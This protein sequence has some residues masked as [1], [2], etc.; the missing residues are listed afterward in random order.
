MNWTQEENKIIRKFYPICYKCKMKKLLPK[1]SFDNIKK[2]ALLLSVFRITKWKV[3]ELI[4][5]NKHKDKTKKELKA[6]FPDRSWLFIK[7]KINIIKQTIIKKEEEILKKNYLK[8]NNRIRLKNPK[9]KKVKKILLHGKK[10]SKKEEEMLK[11]NYLKSNNR[12]K[13]LLRNNRTESAIINKKYQMKLRRPK[14]KIKTTN[15]NQRTNWTDKEKEILKNNY[16]QLGLKVQ[17]LM[18]NR[19]RSAICNIAFKLGLFST[20]KWNKEEKE[21]LKKNY[22]KSNNQIKTLL[23]NSRTE[24]AIINKKYQ[25]RLKKKTDRNKSAITNEAGNIKIKQNK[26]KVISTIPFVENFIKFQTSRSSYLKFLT[27]TK[28]DFKNYLIKN[29]IN[30]EMIKLFLIDYQFDYETSIR[31]NGYEKTR[32]FSNT[33]IDYI[34]YIEKNKLKRILKLH[35]GYR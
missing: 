3:S 5:L 31:N 12:I 8:S 22:L 30:S 27:V 33:L 14:K 10:W 6:L 32:E 7:N 24:S 34:E 16:S 23:G 25:I 11:K 28:K 20:R 4:L 26:F 9:K 17:K 2:Q 1:R 21:I 13:I 35:R 18:P 29:N 15:K 19:T